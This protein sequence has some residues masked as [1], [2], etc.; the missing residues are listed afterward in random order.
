MKMRIGTILATLLA[1]GTVLA[2]EAPAF[3]AIDKDHDYPRHRRVALG[4]DRAERLRAQSM[5][6]SK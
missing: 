2:A 5:G 6:K 1:A 3:S 4:S